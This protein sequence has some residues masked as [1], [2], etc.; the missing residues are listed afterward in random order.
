MNR[1][2]RTAA[3]EPIPAAQSIASSVAHAENEAVE[4]SLQDLLGLN[5]WTEQLSLKHLKIRSM[6]NGTYLS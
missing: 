1:T 3:H 4:V 6:M 5:R 2:I